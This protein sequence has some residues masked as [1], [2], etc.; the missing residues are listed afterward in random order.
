M[1]RLLAALVAWASLPAPPQPVPPPP[2]AARAYYLVDALSGRALAAA[3]EDTRSDP[4]SLT[5]LMTAYVVFGL[6]RDKRLDP[7]KAVTVSERAFRAEGA[8]MFLDPKQ[9]V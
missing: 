1:V 4:A 3:E 9:P 5:K 6:V 2:T 8:R 7:A